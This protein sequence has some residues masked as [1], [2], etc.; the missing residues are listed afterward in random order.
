MTLHSLNRAFQTL[1]LT[2]ILWVGWSLPLFDSTT[3]IGAQDPPPDTEASESNL[4]GD[5]LLGDDL[6]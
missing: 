3:A 2:S 5:D 6:L 4:L 1:L